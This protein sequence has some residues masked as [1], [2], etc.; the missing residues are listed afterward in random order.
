MR[1]VGRV[2][3]SLLL[4]AVIAAAVYG[5]GPAI[6]WLLSS[7]GIGLLSREPVQ[8]VQL[9]TLNRYTPGSPPSPGSAATS[10][11][12]SSTSSDRRSPSA[13]VAKW[14]RQRVSSSCSTTTGRRSRP[15][16][17]GW[18]PAWTASSIRCG[19]WSAAGPRSSPSS[20]CRTTPTCARRARTA[21]ATPGPGTTRLAGPH[22]GEDRHRRR[23]RTPPARSGPR[24]STS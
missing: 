13:L 22:Q 4:V 19:S 20:S 9:S 6:R 11:P 10:R 24:S 7:Q 3:V 17:T 16:L 15:T 2:F 12:W 14:E 23:H 21:S 1:L 18:W 5:G 8:P